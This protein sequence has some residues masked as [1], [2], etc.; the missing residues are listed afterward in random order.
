L[1][2]AVEELIAAG[3]PA[4]LAY[5]PRQAFAFVRL[6]RRRRNQD[7]AERLSLDRL[8][9]HGKAS[10]VRKTLKDLRKWT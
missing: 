4:A 9:Q 3:H 5:T 7:A 8:A 6:A 10:D 1:A 2:A